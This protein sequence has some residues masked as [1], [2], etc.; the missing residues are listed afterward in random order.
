MWARLQVW[1][2]VVVGQDASA[3]GGGRSRRPARAG[4]SWG[5]DGGVGGRYGCGM[6][7]GVV[8]MGARARRVLEELEAAQGAAMAKLSEAEAAASD[9]GQ[10]ELATREAA[11]REALTAMA[12]L[13]GALRVLEAL[14][15]DGGG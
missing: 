7:D 2:W 1:W 6:G 8:R 13:R 14:G 3:R 12:T 11:G 10:A 9:G 4:A 5:L 15:E